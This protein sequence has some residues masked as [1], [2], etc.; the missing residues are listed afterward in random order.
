LGMGQTALIT[1]TL[2]SWFWF[3]MQDETGEKWGIF[4]MKREM[5]MGIILFLFSAKP[6]LAFALGV[7]FLAAGAWRPVAGAMAAF[8]GTYFILRGCLGGFPQGLFDYIQFIATYNPENT[9]AIFKTGLAPQIYT[10]FQSFLSQMSWV[11]PGVAAMLNYIL[12]LGGTALLLYF[13]RINPR[14]TPRTFL[15]MHLSCFLLF[16]TNV[17]A[18]EDILIILLIAISPFF[19]DSS[20]WLGKLVLVFLVV[21]GSQNIGF[22][23]QTFLSAVPLAF[24]A[25]AT[26]VVWACWERCGKLRQQSGSFPKENLQRI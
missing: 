26:L 12:W 16:C 15:E 1:T 18:T 9:G 7:L 22:F 2:L 17:N 6:N 10:N 13:T 5:L 4:S 14:L 21:N 19:R 23:H 11:R 3:K 25:K 8:L 24:L 20:G